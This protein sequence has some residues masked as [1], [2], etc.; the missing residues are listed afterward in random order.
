MAVTAVDAKK[1]GAMAEGSEGKGSFVTT[2]I[3]YSQT[4]GS[5]YGLPAIV[6]IRNPS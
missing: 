5:K 1:S 3:M 4:P 6:T 2:K